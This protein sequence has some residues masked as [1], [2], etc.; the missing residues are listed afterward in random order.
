MLSRRQIFSF[1]GSGC[2]AFAFPALARASLLEKARTHLMPGLWC[3]FHETGFD[4][5]ILVQP[6]GLLVKAAKGPTE[7]AFFISELKIRDGFYAWEFC[8]SV[9]ALRDCMERA[10]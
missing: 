10:A 7:L 5:D 4:A 3:V 2:V 8:R 1:V 6:T 9:Y